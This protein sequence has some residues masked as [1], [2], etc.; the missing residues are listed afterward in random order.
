MSMITTTSAIY[1]CVYIDFNTWGVYLKP[2]LIP[3]SLL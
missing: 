3:L 1:W 2:A